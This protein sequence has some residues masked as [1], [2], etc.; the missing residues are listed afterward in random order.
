MS[1]RVYQ[2]P[3]HKVLYIIGKEEMKIRTGASYVRKV[4]LRLFLWI[5]DNT[6]NKMANLRVPTDKVIEMGFLKE[7]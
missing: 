3:D 6:R 2:W 1:P 7:I 4:L 5:R